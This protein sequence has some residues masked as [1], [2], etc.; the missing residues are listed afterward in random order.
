[1]EKH[2]KTSTVNRIEVAYYTGTIT[3]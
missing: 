2:T 3:V 1:M